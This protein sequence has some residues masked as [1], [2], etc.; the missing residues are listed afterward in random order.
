MIAVLLER[1]AEGA[2]QSA[3]A[4]ENRVSMHTTLA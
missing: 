2:G 3:E 4:V 1:G